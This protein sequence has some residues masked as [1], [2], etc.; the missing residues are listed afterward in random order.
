ME[1]TNEE[2]VGSTITDLKDQIL[3]SIRSELDNASHISECLSKLMSQINDRIQSREILLNYLRELPFSN[4]SDKAIIY[5][6]IYRDQD[7]SK[8]RSISRIL[9]DVNRNLQKKSAFEEILKRL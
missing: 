2:S 4:V 6:T 7:L 1:Y 9:Q 5:L 3:I 8:Y